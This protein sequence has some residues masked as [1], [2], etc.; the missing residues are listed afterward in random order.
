MGG[1]TETT[2]MWTPIPAVMPSPG[3]LV[4][5]GMVV[6]R[7]RWRAKGGVPWPILDGRRP[8]ASSR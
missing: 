8:I 2:T 7:L 3:A 4:D 1:V 5:P 6:M